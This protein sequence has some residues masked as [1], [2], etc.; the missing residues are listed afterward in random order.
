[1]NARKVVRDRLIRLKLGHWRAVARGF[2]T[3]C[4]NYPRS[5]ARKNYWRLCAKYPEIMMSLG[6]NEGSVY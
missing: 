5:Q 1:M 6:W 4:S 3:D 2:S